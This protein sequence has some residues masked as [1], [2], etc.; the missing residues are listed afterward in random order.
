MESS[1]KLPYRF[2]PIVISMEFD[3]YLLQNVIFEH[4]NGAFFLNNQEFVESFFQPS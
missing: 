2:Y 4:L 1:I 3:Q